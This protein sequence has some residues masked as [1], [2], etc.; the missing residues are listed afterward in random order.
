MSISRRRSARQSRKRSP[1]PATALRES[2]ETPQKFRT[3]T[4]TLGIRIGSTRALPP[5]RAWPGSVGLEPGDHMHMHLAH[6]IAECADI[7]LSRI[8]HLCKPAA[9]S[10]DLG[11]QDAGV[12]RTQLGPL[13]EALAARHQDEPGEARIIHE[14]KLAERPVGQKHAV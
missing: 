6:D 4:I 10:G 5:D 2:A 9:G 12:L 8:E 1:R 7:E 14:A 11:R 13:L 3:K